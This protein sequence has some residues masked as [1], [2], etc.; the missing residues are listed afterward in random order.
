M[1]SVLREV[2]AWCP[3]CHTESGGAL[4]V[5]RCLPGRLVANEH[6]WLER[7]CPDHGEVVTLY[8]EDP[9]IL[10]YL[11]RWTA[12][13]KPP[14]PDDPAN[15]EPLPGGYRRGLGARQHCL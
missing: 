3:D 13:T 8:D 1:T 10:A 15:D 11:E 12:P 14:T 4:D 5:A 7:T 6:V 9:A 2:G